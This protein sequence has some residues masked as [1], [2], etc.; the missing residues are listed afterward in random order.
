MLFIPTLLVKVR[1]ITMPRMLSSAKNAYRFVA[2]L[3][4][5]SHFFRRHV[6]MPKVVPSATAANGLQLKSHH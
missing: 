5:Y 2:T 3:Y 1:L 4:K 6:Q